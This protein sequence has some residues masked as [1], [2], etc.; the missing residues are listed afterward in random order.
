MATSS[1]PSLTV[2]CGNFAGGRL[3]QC[4][5]GQ[6]AIVEMDLEVLIA[7]HY[8][9]EHLMIRVANLQAAVLAL[10]GRLA[11]M[12]RPKPWSDAELSADAADK[13]RRLRK[14]SKDLRGGDEIDAV[15]E[16]YEQAEDLSDEGIER[17]LED[18]TGGE[19]GG[20]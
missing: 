5:D 2:F 14:L 19:G 18:L 15:L 20:L 16:R 10:R 6:P 9:T 8:L 7:R 3:Y 11:Q 13:A 1:N 12:S 17:M 4:K